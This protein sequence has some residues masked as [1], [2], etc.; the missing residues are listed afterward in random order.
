VV[1]LVVPSENS[2]GLSEKQ[3]GEMNSPDARKNNL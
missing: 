3:L 2:S 1:L